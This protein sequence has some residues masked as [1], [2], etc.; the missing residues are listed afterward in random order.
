MTTLTVHSVQWGRGGDCPLLSPLTGSLYP[1]SEAGGEGDFS[2]LKIS[3]ISSEACKV[4]TKE[5]GGGHGL[6]AGWSQGSRNQV[7]PRRITKSYKSI[8]KSTKPSKGS[9]PSCPRRVS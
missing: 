6:P 5:Y 3:P 1:L 9:E 2:T 4:M 8:L 7:N